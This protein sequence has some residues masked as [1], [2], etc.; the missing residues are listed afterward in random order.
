MTFHRYSGRQ[1]GA[2]TA[3]TQVRL[4]AELLDLA[5]QRWGMEST[6]TT[7]QPGFLLELSGAPD[8]ALDGQYLIVECDSSGAA[9]E[10]SR[11]SWENTLAVVPASMPYRPPRR[12]KRPTIHGFESATVVGPSGEEIYTDEH[13]RVKVQFHW[14]REG[15][16]DEHSSCWMRAMQAWSGPGFGTWFL[17]RI[18]ME[19]VIAFLGGNPDRPV[20]AGCLYNGANA[21]PATLPDDKTQSVIRTKSSVD[22]DGFNEMRFEDKAGSERIFVH[23]QKDYDE[24]VEHCHTTHVKV[25]QSN[26]VDHDH[27]ETV[28]NDQ[29]LHVKND[30]KK[31]V[32]NDEHT[33]VGGNR[34]E[35]VTGHEQIHIHKFRKTK[36]EEDDKLVVHA[37]R[38]MHVDGKD[39]EDIVGGRDVTV[40]E[41]DALKVI[42]GANR[43]V[44]VSGKYSVTIDGDQYAQ[45]QKGTEKFVQASPQT[46]VESAGEFHVKVG[47]CH[48]I[49]K[50]DG[51]IV[52]K[53]DAKIGLECGG[54][55]LELTP[56]GIALEGTSIQAAAGESA[57]K[58]ESS[59]ATLKGAM[60]DML[61]DMFATIKGTLVRI[62]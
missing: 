53:S 35:D 11:G 8:G 18:G 43:T 3:T 56:Q 62:N 12:A 36:V 50:S 25:D 60:V 1:Y 38:E 44:H 54:S 39:K 9:T 33:V 42:S 16:R 61:A 41:F 4:R 59:K 48:L 21:A 58:L 7:A 55:K 19:V 26:T 31:N 14:D 47:P 28:G 27:T 46:Y 32:D 30:R 52:L 6:V 57:L 17:P 49:A 34:T 29:T 24:V 10:G 40:S 45:K 37:N 13:G 22:S 23:A 51:T 15:Q 20:V 2:N 5:S